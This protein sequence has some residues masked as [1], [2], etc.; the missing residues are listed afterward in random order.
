ML[1]VFYVKLIMPTE[2]KRD[3]FNDNLINIEIEYKTVYNAALVIVN[4]NNMIG[5]TFITVCSINVNSTIA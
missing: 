5:L 4:H 1:T 3:R 2:I